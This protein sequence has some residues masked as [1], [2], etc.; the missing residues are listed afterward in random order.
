MADS[1]NYRPVLEDAGMAALP[2][3]GALGY[4]F[5]LSQMFNPLALGVTAAFGA[6]GLAMYAYRAAGPGVADQRRALVR[7]GAALPMDSAFGTHDPREG[8]R[9]EQILKAHLSNAARK[10][11]L[12][13]DFQAWYATDKFIEAM[14]DKAIPLAQRR[15]NLFFIHIPSR[16]VLTT[17]QAMRKFMRDDQLE[18]VAAHELSHVKTQDHLSVNSFLESAM[19]PTVSAGFWMTASVAAINAA[20]GFIGMEPIL[21]P[22]LQEGVNIWSSLAAQFAAGA[23]F[24][25]TSGAASRMA[26][27]RADRNA[28]AV[29][30]NLAAA[31]TAVD[32]LYAHEKS[33]FSLGNV[34][35]AMVRKHPRHKARRKAL[36]R[37]WT[38]I[39]RHAALKPS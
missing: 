37:N 1:W 20:M 9:H 19:L 26:E 39:R 4:A 15:E 22:S 36:D 32:Q 3:A 5:A 6:A 31:Q 13:D 18:F 17:P 24:V 28:L 8:K 33:G 27:K 29:T 7:E 35:R 12:P 34:F 10:M 23:G 11:D 30:G 38:R 25:W 21:D 14:M 16:T 2:V